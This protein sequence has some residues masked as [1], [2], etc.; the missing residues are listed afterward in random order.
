MLLFVPV[1]WFHCRWGVNLPA[2]V[3]V[4]ATAPALPRHVRV[5]VVGWLCPGAGPVVAAL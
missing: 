4:V 3:V 5:R 1:L 2:F